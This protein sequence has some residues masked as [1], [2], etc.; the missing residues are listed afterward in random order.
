MRAF[1]IVVGSAERCGRP[2]CWGDPLPP[3]EERSLSMT[4]PSRAEP[5]TEAGWR[6]LASEIEIC[7]LTFEPS[8]YMIARMTP[9]RYSQFCALARA[10]ELVGE[11]WTLLIV[12][13]LLL[14]PKRFSD[15][16]AGLDGVSSSVLAGR[17][18]PAG[19][20]G[21]GGGA[22]R[23][24]P[25]NFGGAPV[26][27]PLP[28]AAAAGRAKGAGLDAAGPRGVRPPNRDARALLR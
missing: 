27:R 13:D 24:A 23:P 2:S 17:L 7:G 26:G 14:G 21:G 18:A 22:R 5:S 11:R 3:I 19:G 20:G 6:G 4:A 12:R 8:P 16:R 9:T 25:R 15:L 10:A 1:S 28:S